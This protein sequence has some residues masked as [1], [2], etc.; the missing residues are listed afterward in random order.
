LSNPHFDAEVRVRLQ[1]AT[2]QASEN[3]TFAKLG[4][5]NLDEVA[6]S[7]VEPKPASKK[8]D[9]F[10][11]LIGDR[12]QAF[13]RPVELH[14]VQDWPLVFGRN[15]QEFEA[16]RTTLIEDAKFLLGT[17]DGLR[18][19]H[20]GWQRLAQLEAE[21]PKSHQ[22]FVA[23]AFADE[24]KPAYDEGF[25]PCLDDLGYDVIRVD[26]EHYL[27]KID[28]FIIASIRKSGLLV[29]DF[30]LVRQSVFFEA[31]FGMGL[32][33]PVVFT[34]RDT[35][36]DFEEFAKH[37]DTRQYNCVPWKDP[38]DLK[39]RLRTRIE[40]AILVRPKPLRP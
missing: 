14:A 30:T 1:W 5:D 33:I 9:H 23:M 15:A 2:R 6:G 39:T 27:G 8:L 3:G 36:E 21:R 4:S 25:L 37:L 13:G 38:A 16:L 18:L 26:R 10:V 31:G 19:T 7:V 24:M 17:A 11:L 28:D 32:G 34:C 35:R 22:A 20:A 40:A 29:V 12:T